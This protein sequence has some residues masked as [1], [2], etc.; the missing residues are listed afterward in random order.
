MAIAFNGVGNLH[1]VS[2]A[3]FI[4]TGDVSWACRIQF[5]STS[6]LSCIICIDGAAYPS[7]AEV[8]NMLFAFFI[9][10]ASDSWDLAYYHEHGAGVNDTYTFLTNFTNGTWYH[11]AAIRDNTA[12]TVKV[13]VDL[14]LL[15]TY[16]YTNVP[17]TTATTLPLYYAARHGNAN[18]LSAKLAEVVLAT[19]VWTSDELIAS[20]D[21]P[22]S[23]VTTLQR[24][25]IIG[26]FTGAPD[27]DVV[28]TSGTQFSGAF[29]A[30]NFALF[31]HPN[32]PQRD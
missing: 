18:R 12:K 24:M 20:K 15:D 4:L 27:A 28:D 22:G 23:L 10:G 16:T 25:S 29:S 14:T 3:Q 2:D 30:G 6:D 9:T 5:N 19:H 11:L 13:Y 1:T 31:D 32:V 21:F 26:R 17:T 8:D 7:D